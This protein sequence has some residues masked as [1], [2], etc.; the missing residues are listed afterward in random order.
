MTWLSDVT[1]PPTQQNLNIRCLVNRCQLIW[2]RMLVWQQLKLG[3]L[4]H[5][6]F[7]WRYISS[8]A[9]TYKVKTVSQRSYNRYKSNHLPNEQDF[10]WI[11]ILY[12]QPIYL[13]SI[14]GRTPN[15]SEW[16]SKRI[17][18]GGGNKSCKKQPRS[19]QWDCR[20]IECRYNMRWLK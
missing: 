2:M 7:L 9:A 11:S 18:L 19:N 5:N 8:A 1:N 14:S 13:H 3:S 4:L 10:V 15:N 12:V 20:W 6:R 17:K 16:I